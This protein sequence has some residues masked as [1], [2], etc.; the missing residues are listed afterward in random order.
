MPTVSTIVKPKVVF[1][2]PGLLEFFIAINEFIV[3]VLIWSSIKRSTM[4]KI[5]E[6][7]FCSLPLLF[8]ILR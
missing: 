1:I 6:Y 8:D 7:L 2:H 4:E 3:H 5:V